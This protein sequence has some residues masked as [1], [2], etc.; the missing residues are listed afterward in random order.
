MR[1]GLVGTGY[2]ARVTHAAVLAREP[3]VD[4]SAIWGRDPG[5]AAALGDEFGVGVH[6]DFTEFLS[7][8]DAVT[9]AVTP[10]VQAELGAQAAGAG[11]HLLCDKPLATTVAGAEHLVEA[12]DLARV[13]TVVFFTGRFTEANRQWLATL[14][15]GDWKG[16]WA[17]WIVSAFAPGSPYASSPWR[18]EKGA[19]WDVGPHALSILIA[20]LGPVQAV[21]AT[22][23]SGDLVHL[24]LRHEGG[25]TSTASLT[26]DAPTAAI[27]VELSLW[28]PD[29]LSTMPR[30]GSTPQDAY[31]L[32]LRELMSNVAAGECSHPCDVHFGAAVVRS[33]ADAEQQIAARRG[34]GHS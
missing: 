20:A 31:G 12:V 24:I 29:G 3:G 18:R 25:A 14:D 10:D 28:G 16:A 2:W 15:G 11:K 23:G 5:K 17:R 26:L 33:L 13:S 32:A 30:G 4:F 21:T 6:T 8:V 1:F 22:G 19:L 7:H 27:N 34:S 9:F